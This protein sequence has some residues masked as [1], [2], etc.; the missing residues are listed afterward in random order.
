[1]GYIKK[2]HIEG[3]KKFKKIDINFNENVNIIIGENESGKSTVLEAISIVLGQKYKNVD[4]AVIGELLNIDN[5]N[6]FKCNPCIDN[7]PQIIIQVE[8][9]TDYKHPESFFGENNI[10]K[11]ENFG[12]LFECK[13]IDD[14]EYGL[15]EKIKSG[16]IPLEYYSLSWNTFQGSSYSLLKK[17]LETLFIDT[18]EETRSNSFNYYNKTIFNKNFD[19]KIKM[20]IK[21]N[22]RDNLHQSFLEL[23]MD[24]IDEKRCFGINDKKVILES[25][26][27]IN[28]DGIP[29]ENKESGMENLIKTEI[30]LTRQEKHFDVILIEEPENHL[31]YTNM[32]KMIKEIVNKQDSS[33]IILTTHSDLIASSLD[34]KNIL[35][36]QENQVKSLKEVKEDDSKFFIKAPNNNLLTFLLSKRII[37]VE[38]PTEY[39]LVPMFYKQITGNSIEED[40]ISIIACN[41]LSYQRYLNI[42]KDLGKKVCVITDNDEKEENIKMMKEY[43]QNNNFS[44]IFM[45]KDINNFTWEVCLFNV[46]KD[47]LKQIISTE[48]GANYYYKRN[49]ALDIHCKKM[50]NNKVDTAYELLVNEQITLTPPDYVKDAIEWVRS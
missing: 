42:S 2:I 31:S 16:I 25:I 41:G 46:N 35:W 27:S 4:K 1:M 48:E 24:P 37:L 20:K 26:I 13:Y 33:Q 10:E 49:N 43:N 3:F 36:I 18:S 38:G 21:D 50:L 12:I 44:H 19:N 39:L 11:K 6:Y 40:E 7:L 14:P 5:I 28:E 30:A 45:S 34:L 17:P 9:V 23:Q 15:D 22:F 47:I 8:F 32:N 29:I